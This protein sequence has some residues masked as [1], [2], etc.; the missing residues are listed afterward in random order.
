VQ[1]LSFADGFGLLTRNIEGFVRGNGEVV[2]LALVCLFA[3]GHLLIEGAPGVAKTSLAKAIARSIAADRRRIQFTPD[4]LPWDVTGGRVFRQ[5]SGTFRFEPGPVFTNIL[6]AD[7]INRSSPRTQSALLEVMAERQVTV[8]GTTYGVAEPFMCIATQNP[9]EHR[10]TFPLPEAQIDRFMMKVTMKPPQH[11]AELQVLEGGIKRRTP[12]SVKPVLTVD[13]VRKMIAEVREVH[14]TV[15]VLEYI[16][17][18]IEATRRESADLEAG[19][20]PRA[21]IAL[22]LAA[23][24][25][26]KSD[27]RD[28]VCGDDVKKVACPV[29]RHRLLLRRGSA[30]PDPDTIIEGLIEEISAPS[31]DEAA[32]EAKRERAAELAP[33]PAS[34]PGHPSEPIREPVP[35]A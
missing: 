4:L 27:G 11:S 10:G 15:T 35:G 17:A 23:Q 8:D 3:E 28:F 24:A 13:Q 18:V 20:S 30:G 31:Q 6:L 22:A 26:A 21:G 16:L 32:R 25:H 34:E 7:E 19:V 9:I 33:E 12:E 29:L 5:D 1:E 2:R 14:V